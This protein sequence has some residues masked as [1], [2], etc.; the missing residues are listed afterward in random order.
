M[1]KSASV[2]SCVAA[3]S[4]NNYQCSGSH[5]Q[6]NVGRV[7]GTSVQLFCDQMGSLQFPLWLFTA[8]VLYKSFGIV[9]FLLSD[10]ALAFF[11]LSV[12]GVS[13]ISVMSL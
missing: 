11:L 4:A 9:P 3:S 13:P 1:A 2:L 10:P 12:P 6:L 7:R 8:A 5:A